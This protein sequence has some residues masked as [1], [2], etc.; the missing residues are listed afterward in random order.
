M[1]GHDRG[2]GNHVIGIGS[3]A[4]PQEKLRRDDGEQAKHGF[5][6]LPYPARPGLSHLPNQI[7]ETRRAPLDP[8]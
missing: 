2:D 4:H 6:P 7:V 1:P 5:S 8:D 3:V